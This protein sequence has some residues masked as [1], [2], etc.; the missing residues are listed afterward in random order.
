QVEPAVHHTLHHVRRTALRTTLRHRLQV[1][2]E[3]ALWIARAA[4]EDIPRPSFA[5]GNITLAALGA[6]QPLNQ[7]LL[8]VLALRIARARYKLPVRPRTQHQLL[9]ALRTLLV[10]R[11][12]RLLLLLLAQPP[13]RLARRIGVVIRARHI[14]PEWPAPQHHHLAA[15]LAILFRG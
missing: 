9:P 15:V 11:H 6:L 1:R 2:R 10:Q 7:V 12:R 3:V 14:R 13:H 4:P 8:N 5:F